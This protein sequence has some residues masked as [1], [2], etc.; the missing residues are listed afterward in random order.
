M[1]Q[2]LAYA[3]PDLSTINNS[4][5]TNIQVLD[6]DTGEPLIGVLIYN[7]EQTTVIQTDVDGRAVLENFGHRE[8]ANFQYLGY[9]D[10]SLP[11]H[12]IRKRRGLIKM[13]ASNQLDSVVVVGRRDDLI[14]EIPFQVGR[15]S[16]SEIAFNNSQTA[17]D[18]LA[19]AGLAYVQKSQM[20]GGSPV[21]RGFEANKVLLVLDGVRLNNAIYRNGHLQNAITIDNGTLEQV[22]VIY[23]PGSLMY[24][25][26][27]LG[28]VVHYRTKEPQVLMGT[29]RSD[30][31]IKTNVQTRFASAN[32]EKSAHIDIDYR[33]HR[34][35]AFTS[36]TYTNYDDLRAGARRSDEFPELG[37][38]NFYIFRNENIDEKIKSLDPNIQIGT[39]YSQ[40][41]LLQKVRYQASDSL[42]FIWNFQYSTSSDVP[43]YDN[44]TDSTNTARN[45]KWAEWYYGPQKRLLA[46]MKMRS[47]KTRG[48]YDRATY[49]G[50]FQRID[51]DRLKRKWNKIN[52]TFNLENVFVYSMTMDFDKELTKSGLHQLSYGLDG[53]YNTVESVAGNR[54]IYT[55]RVIFNEPTRYPN[56]GSNMLTAGGYLNY[57]W[58]TRDSTLSFQMGARY[59]YVRLFA[60]FESIPD[61]E[62]IWPDE[63][64][65]GITSVNTSPTW[66]AGINYNSRNQW[67]IRA[68]AATAFRSP[69]ID[70]F[71]K[72]RESG[73]GFVV[74]PNPDLKPEE[75]ITG[76]L[77]LGKSFGNVESQ[78]G[79]AFQL[80]S[81]GFYTRLSN[82]IVRRSGALPNGATTLFY[83]GSD[84]VVQQNFNAGNGFIYGL[85]GNL[86][87]RLGDHWEIKSNLSW[88]KG[89]TEF[90][91]DI[92]DT[93]VPLDH[94]PPIY[95]QTSIGFRSEKFRFE[96][97]LRYNGEKPLTEYAVG[98]ILLDGDGELELDRDGTTDNLDET[99]TCHEQIINGRRVVTCFG[100]P[101][102]STLNF[103]SSY[104][105]NE[106]FSI[107][108]ALE[109]VLDIH[110]RTFASGVSAP[111]RNF[112]I[113]LRGNF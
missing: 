99:D 45:L 29:G 53:N 107:N 33:T 82:A 103:Y 77:T 8:E 19:N 5:S 31:E 109:N 63:Y 39:A 24:G 70:D 112:I 18:I 50:S 27:A 38:R 74:V 12:E 61:F 54:N 58:K 7:N 15:I 49:I 52:R 76:E 13:Y 83:D 37:L 20:G 88:T 57:Q 59:S 84:L 55:N 42:Y 108:L 22:E 36:L 4:T 81:T 32:Q 93:L 44:L 96:T 89:R 48:I 21:L 28:G 1:T 104:R 46:S 79:S 23:G 102:W 25:S 60:K 101:S 17:A 95:G 113:T 64:L 67:Q 66:A 90:K 51:E 62:I 105:F 111:G 85:S 14:R 35:G 16:K 3:N 41:D 69:N 87:T 71:G 34:W 86:Y 98:D 75:S 6:G 30:Y 100:T 80:S 40:I 106:K 2:F 91:N 56:G 72:V 73:N 94:I 26:D 43:R 9:L 97:V 65:A 92:V 47:L 11:L 10:L 78:K 110:Y 68:L